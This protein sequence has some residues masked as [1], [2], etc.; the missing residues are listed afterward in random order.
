VRILSI[1]RAKGL[2]API[3][4]LFDSADNAR[5]NVDTVPLSEEGRLAVGFRSGCQPPGWDVLVKKEEGKARAENRRLLYVACT[6]ARDLLVIPKPP[7]D[8]RAGDFWRELQT[9]LP[10]AS[11]ADVQ[12]V[13]AEAL[14]EEPAARPDLWSLAGAGGGDA[15]AALWDEERARLIAAAAHRP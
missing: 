5:S 7:P 1:H 2:E 10:N 11:D 3:V 15:V 12:V 8:A 6:R 9:R 13:D 4:A 14:A